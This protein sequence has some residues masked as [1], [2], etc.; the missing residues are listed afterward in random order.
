MEKQWK[1]TWAFFSA[2]DQTPQP[3]YYSPFIFLNDLQIIYTYQASFAANGTYTAS[4]VLLL[5][6]LLD[7]FN[8]FFQDNLGKP[9]P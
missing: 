8:G 1:L 3:E 6:L 2:C 9:A 4:V 7:Q 5:L